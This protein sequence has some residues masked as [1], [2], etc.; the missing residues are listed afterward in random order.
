[1]GYSL[2][3]CDPVTGN[4]LHT[5]LPHMMACGMYAVG[6]T[7]EMWLHITSNYA[8]W[9]CKP[10]AFGDKGIFAI[11]DM[12]AIESVPVINKAIAGLTA[13]DE[14]LSKEEVERY[15]KH[16]VDGYWLPTKQNALKPLYQLR[17]LALMRPDGIWEVVC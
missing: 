13:L 7:T 5:E 16:N 4:T 14:D 11:N 1:M 12:G 2:Y 10:I 9:Y 3:L 17:A 15:R 8:R 6:G